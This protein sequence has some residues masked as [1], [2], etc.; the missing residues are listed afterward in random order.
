[1]FALLPRLIERAGATAAGAIT[2][3]YTVLVAGNDMDEPIADEVRGLVD[4]HIVLDR[5]L[6]Q[7]GHFPPVDVV[8]S[9]S[10][11]MGRVIDPRHAEA[12]ARVRARLAI[13]DEHRDLVTLGAYQTGRDRKIDAAIAAYPATERLLQQRR[14]EPADWDRG[15]TQLIE[16]AGTD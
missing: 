3:I 11:L 10:R 1:V 13:Y 4:G 6:A 14:D 15:I 16:L 5:R 12:A 8:A 9:A 7:R 2:A